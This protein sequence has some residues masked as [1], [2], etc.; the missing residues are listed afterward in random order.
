M[1]SLG[2]KSLSKI[3]AV[4]INILWWIE[5]IGSGVLIIVMLITYFSGRSMTLTVPVTFSSIPLS[6]IHS[7]K[8]GLPDGVLNVMNGNFSIPVENNLQNT[9]MLLTA[10]IAICAVL[11]VVTYQLKLIFSSLSRDQ[12]FDELNV[13]RIRNIGIVLIIFSFLQFLSNITLNWFLVGHFSWEDGIKLTYLFKI[14]YLVTGVVL[15]I[16][17]EIFKQGASLKEETNLTI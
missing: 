4:I 1:K 9:L 13:L 12:P 15:I 14:S 17:A 7:I 2:N 11:I 16:V 3:F 10:G 5:W 8:S 6:K